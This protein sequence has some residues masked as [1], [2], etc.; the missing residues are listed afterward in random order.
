MTFFFHV[1]WNTA[2]PHFACISNCSLWARLTVSYTIPECGV[3]CLLPPFSLSHTH[4][5]LP[6]SITQ[7]LFPL[8]QN[9]YRAGDRAP[10]LAPEHRSQQLA[11]VNLP[12][13]RS[14]VGAPRQQQF[15]TA[16]EWVWRAIC[17]PKSLIISTSLSGGGLEYGVAVGVWGEEIREGAIDDTRRV[18]GSNEMLYDWGE[19]E[20]G[21]LRVV[22][23]WDHP[24]HRKKKKI[25]YS[26]R[27]QPQWKNSRL[28]WLIVAQMFL[29]SPY[30]CF[31]YT[32]SNGS[33]TGRFSE[34]EILWR[35][36]EAYL[37]L[38]AF[39]S[40][41]KRRLAQQSWYYS[42]CTLQKWPPFL[43]P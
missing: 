24:K 41:L 39:F 6:C 7:P 28:C 42:V 14:R 17:W 12:A 10:A 16:C 19:R 23:P 34:A 35:L 38:H 13:T 15:S 37:A 36:F 25:P 31:R 40:G 1:P 20:V 3:P 9:S 27:V 18:P 11:N 8:L 4:P 2:A 33:H 26:Q 30:N 21:Y 5:R 29:V 43:C 32:K 22:S